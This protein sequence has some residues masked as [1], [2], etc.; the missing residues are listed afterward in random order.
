MPIKDP[1]RDRLVRALAEGELLFRQGDRPQA[2]FIVLSGSIKLFRQGPDGQMAPIGTCRPGDMAGHLDTARGEPTTVGAIATTDTMVQV[3]GPEF[4]EEQLDHS[5]LPNER[6]AAVETRRGELVAG[7]VATHDRRRGLRGRDGK[8]KSAYWTLRRKLSRGEPALLMD[9]I[10]MVESKPT[11]WQATA[12][13]VALLAIIGG[14]ILWS[15]TSELDVVVTAE[16]R[17]LPESGEM[18]LAP[19]ETGTLKTM[20]VRP[21]DIV[22][23]GQALATLDPTFARSDLNKA[24]Q[25]RANL[26]ARITR[27]RAEISGEPPAT[28][29][30]DPEI[31]RLNRDLFETRRQAVTAR[32]ATYAAKTDELRA[33]LAK[34]RDGL[35][36]TEK[37]LKIYQDMESMRATL[38]KDKVGSRMQLLEA[39]GEKAALER[40]QVELARPIDELE[41]RMETVEAEQAAYLAGLREEA[42]RE[43][44]KAQDELASVS[45]ESNKAQ[46]RANLVTL[47]AP[48]DGVVLSVAEQATGAVVQQGTPLVTLTPLGDTLRVEALLRP[49]DVA[50]V[51]V[52]QKVRLKLEALPF[53]KHGTLT[54]KLRVLSPN[55]VTDRTPGTQDLPE[56]ERKI[57]YRMV[58][59]ITEN[60]LT[61]V[62]EAFQLLPGMKA[63]AE[64]Q[65]GKRTVISYFL[66]P[67]LRVFDESLR[68]A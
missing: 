28:F 68:E 63:M 25:D 14:A 10:E 42:A 15:V 35:T 67:V 26:A 11:P 65:L 22:R 51:H 54:G 44:E 50:D 55:I 39:Q 37:Q 27:L 56:Q 32:V 8:L 38:F 36:A 59:D 48:R 43:L 66:Y 17:V 45:E 24:T 64:L 31:D 12:L 9:D 3:V 1:V 40:D 52:G 16:G 30:P 34:K 6:D 18:A 57:G 58:I 21:G 19:L 5:Q 4:F 2:A 60:N 20:N 7:F 49:E 62:G 41:Q 53:Q 33:E 13:L 61:N 47:T 46:H 23:E 29:Y